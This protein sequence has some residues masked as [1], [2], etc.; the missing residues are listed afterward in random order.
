MNTTLDR[1]KKILLRT[2]KLDSDAMT[3][4]M[5]LEKLG[6]DSLGIS[7]LLFDAED[8]FKVKFKSEPG[9]LHTLGDVVR[10]I[11]NVIMT[12]QNP[13]GFAP[14]GTAPSQPGS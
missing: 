14:V 12:Q 1:L 6:I 13:I 9:E 8:E 4:D 5:P 11:D 3:A 2:Y 7:L 10:Y